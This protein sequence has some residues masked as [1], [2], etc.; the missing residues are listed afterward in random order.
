M[1]TTADRLQARGCYKQI[2]N[3]IYRSY[4]KHK[5]IK[6]Y[7]LLNELKNISCLQ[8]SFGFRF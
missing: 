2:Y 7:V 8:R 3:K 4:I 6:F 1:K 5:L